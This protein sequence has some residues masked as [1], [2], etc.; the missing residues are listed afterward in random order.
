[1]VD[2]RIPTG[3]GPMVDEILAMLGAK[4]MAA[5]AFCA[6]ELAD[7]SRGVVEVKQGYLAAIEGLQFITGG[8]SPKECKEC[9]GAGYVCGVDS[10]GGP[11]PEDASRCDDCRSSGLA[12]LFRDWTHEELLEICTRKFG[13]PKP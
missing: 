10:G 6:M 12:D 9:G 4:A 2:V 5:Q 3:Y 8:L 1:M 11:D 13:A 7:F